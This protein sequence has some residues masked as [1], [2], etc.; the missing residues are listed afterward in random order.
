MAADRSSAI[1]VTDFVREHVPFIREEL[2]NTAY[3]LDL[4]RLKGYTIK[5]EKV[6]AHAGNFIAGSVAEAYE[7]LKLK[8]RTLRPGRIYLTADRRILSNKDKAIEVG[9]LI[10]FTDSLSVEG[11]DE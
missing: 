5:K 6:F 7:K 9:E 2:S 11:E 8:P 3:D 4:L 10:F 1:D